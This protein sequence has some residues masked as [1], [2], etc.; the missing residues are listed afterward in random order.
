M[1]APLL[2]L[3]MSLSGASPPS[4]KRC[5]SFLVSSMCAAR[6]RRGAGRGWKTVESGSAEWDANQKGGAGEKCHQS[7]VEVV[8]PPRTASYKQRRSRRWINWYHHVA[9]RGKNINTRARHGCHAPTT[10]AASPRVRGMVILREQRGK[11]AG[12]RLASCASSF[13]RGSAAQAATL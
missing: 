4:K 5:A 2:A 13:T 12:G 1:R 9:E 3:F 8:I 11:R 6:R 7:P 10:A